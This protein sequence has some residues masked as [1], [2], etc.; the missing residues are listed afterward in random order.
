MVPP[1]NDKLCRDYQR[2]GS[3][4]YGAKSIF[5]HDQSSTPNGELTS[6]QPR[7]KNEETPEEREEK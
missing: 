6:K 1:S 7:K 5:S 4:Q 3:C 2:T